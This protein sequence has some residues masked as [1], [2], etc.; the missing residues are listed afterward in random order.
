MRM[1]KSTILLI[2]AIVFSLV[3]CTSGQDANAESQTAFNILGEW[4]Y[5]LIAT[6][7]NTYDNGT[8]TFKGDASRGTW[9]QLNFYEI[10]YS[11]TFTVKG[12]VITL[13][14]DGIWQGN[15]TDA[16]HMSGE[17]QNNE[18]S[19]EWTAVKK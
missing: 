8:I 5:T 16:S 19:G 3:G 15:I 4:E 1:K 2:L 14:G 7:G 11:G 17:W 12:N 18:A 13:A 6:D 10:E 9:T